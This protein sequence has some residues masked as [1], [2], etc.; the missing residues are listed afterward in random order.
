MSGGCKKINRIILKNNSPINM[1]VCATG[2]LMS[3]RQ[4]RGSPYCNWDHSSSPPPQFFI[5]SLS[6]PHM[7]GRGNILHL[8]YR[9]GQLQLTWVKNKKKQSLIFTLGSY[10]HWALSRAIAS[11]TNLK[12][13]SEPKKKKDHKLKAP[14]MRGSFI[15]RVHL[16]VSSFA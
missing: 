8:L 2:L 3:C 6:L 10:E 4:K 5:F 13:T 16:M 9:R 15:A 1:P 7:I 14:Q 11:N 12:I